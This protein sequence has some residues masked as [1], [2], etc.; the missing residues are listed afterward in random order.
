MSKKRRSEIAAMGGAASGGNFAKDHKRA[1]K[2]G[3]KGGLASKRTS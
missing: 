1:A 3:R 2:E